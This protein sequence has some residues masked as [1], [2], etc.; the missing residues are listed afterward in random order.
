VRYISKARRNLRRPPVVSAS[1][2]GWREAFKDASLCGPGFDEGF[3]WDPAG[4]VAQ[5]Q[6][7][8]DDVI[9]RADHGQETQG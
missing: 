7:D 2:G 6:G 8:H 9:E 4:G 1:G 3:R 5:R